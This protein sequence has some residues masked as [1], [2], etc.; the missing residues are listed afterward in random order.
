MRGHDGS[1]VIVFDDHYMPFLGRA[2]LL[3]N[4]TTITTMVD[5]WRPETNSFHLLC[6]DMTVT[7]EDVAM[8][9][10]SPIKG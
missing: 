2:N 1:T 5:R 10:G 3:F 9:L 4:D 7:L 8:I 6:G